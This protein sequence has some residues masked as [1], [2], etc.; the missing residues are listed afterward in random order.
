MHSPPVEGLPILVVPW[1]DI[2]IGTQLFS[3]LDKGNVREQLSPQKQLI[4]IGE[5][6]NGQILFHTTLSPCWKYRRVNYHSDFVGKISMASLLELILNIFCSQSWRQCGQSFPTEVWCRAKRK[7][8]EAIKS[9]SGRSPFW[10][11][12][13]FVHARHF[14]KRNT[15]QSEYVYA[16]VCIHISILPGLAY[17]QTN[18]H[19][20]E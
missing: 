1:R 10:D 13:L 7:Q 16:K 11:T 2:F 3:W 9:Q 4:R 19:P 20:V 5:P 18:I 17:I 8:S 14:C 15:C 12:H 6:R